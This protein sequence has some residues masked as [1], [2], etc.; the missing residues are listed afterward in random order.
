[1]PGAGGSEPRSIA[2]TQA[3]VEA[4]EAETSVR[5]AGWADVEES[6]EVVEAPP[7]AGQEAAQPESRP[8][9]EEP[10]PQQDRPT[11]QAV[12]AERGVVVPPSIV[13]AVVPT[14]ETPAPPQGST[15][16]VIDLTV[17]DPPS[18]KGKQKAD[19]ETVDAS[20]RPGTSAALGDDLA[21]ASA[22]W[23]DYAGL[24]LVRAEEELPRWGR[25]TLK[26]RDASNPS[27]E[28]FFALD[29]KDEVQHWEFVEGLRKHSLQSLRMVMDTLVRGMS[30]A[31]EV[32][33]VR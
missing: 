4:A 6:R 20:D 9:R 11:E 31:F 17:D 25:S 19:V 27:A 24:A 30:E 1:V 15:P 32:S 5:D 21:K 13:Q 26:F 16:A 3:T 12:E 18:D 7:E 10:Q 23:P 14:V 33:R 28:P 22:R 2:T 8:A 29:D